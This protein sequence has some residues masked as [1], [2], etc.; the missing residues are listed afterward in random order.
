MNEPLWPEPIVWVASKRRTAIDDEVLPLALFQHGCV[1]KAQ[2]LKALDTCG[3]KWRIAYCSS[4]LAAVQAAVIGGLGIGVIGENT[5]LDGMRV[6][7][8]DKPFSPLKP[9]Q[10]VLR[11]GS[12]DPSP[13]AKHLADHVVQTLKRNPVSF[14]VV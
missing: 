9:S 11:R 1:L 5:L 12:S 14:A 3:R 7:G 4:S 8:P 2:A 13:A 10:I 6:L